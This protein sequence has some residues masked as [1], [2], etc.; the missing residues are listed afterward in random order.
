MTPITPLLD[1]TR[2]I[3]RQGLGLPIRAVAVNMALA[4]NDLP[5]ARDI[6][7]LLNMLQSAA[8]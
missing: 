3:P 6:T 5:T 8:V 4:P 7:A 1:F 2:G